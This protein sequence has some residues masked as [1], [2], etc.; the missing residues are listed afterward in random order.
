V[1]GSISRCSLHP[2][3]TIAISRAFKNGQ[4]HLRPVCSAK[5]SKA[6]LTGAPTTSMSVDL[7]KSMRATCACDLKVYLGGVTVPD[8]ITTAKVEGV[9]V[10]KVVQ[11]VQAHLRC[12]LPYSGVAAGADVRVDAEHVQFVLGDNGMDLT[13]GRQSSIT[14][15]CWQETNLIDRLVP[16]AE[17]R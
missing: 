1:P 2:R 15:S 3:Q 8:L 5:R 6:S 17:T 11:E 13:T 9:C 10:G 14:N 16:D 7:S 12:A 4:A